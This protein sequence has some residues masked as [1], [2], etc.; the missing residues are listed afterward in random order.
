[1][2]T[3]FESMGSSLLRHAQSA[4]TQLGREFE[5]ISE[6]HPVLVMPPTEASE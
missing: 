5:E 6:A 3:V 2:V 1:M 4:T